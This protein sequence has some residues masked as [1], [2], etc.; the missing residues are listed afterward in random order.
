MTEQFGS[1]VDATLKQ[2]T[3]V[4][5]NKE[6]VVLISGFDGIGGARRAME[7]LGLHVAFSLKLKSILQQGG[8]QNTGGLTC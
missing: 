3:E 5:N 8:W 4:P 1:N 6:D 7:L 2:Q